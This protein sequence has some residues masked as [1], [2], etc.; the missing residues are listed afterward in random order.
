MIATLMAEALVDVP[1]IPPEQLCPAFYI[2]A[3]QLKR[4]HAFF[5]LARAL[6]YQATGASRTTSLGFLSSRTPMKTGAR[7]FLSRFPSANLFSATNFGLPQCAFFFIKGVSPSPHPPF[8]FEGRSKKGPPP[9]P[10]ARNF[11]C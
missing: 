5:L 3:S 11:L 9:L 6:N 2:P 4:T 7:I 10:S 1:L 8:F